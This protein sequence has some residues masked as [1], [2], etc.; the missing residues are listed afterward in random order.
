SY[1][2][3]EW[4]VS[5][6]RTVTPRSSHGTISPPSRWLI[7]REAL[8]KCVYASMRGN[9]IATPLP[10]VTTPLVPICTYS[11]RLLNGDP[12]EPRRLMIS[13]KRSGA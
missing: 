7:C 3:L 2:M 8:L 1:L 4:L 12:A 5:C 11:R 10:L 13:L 6:P 9:L